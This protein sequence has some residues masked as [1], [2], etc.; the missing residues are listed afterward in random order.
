MTKYSRQREAIKNFLISRTDHPTAETV[1]ENIK[2]LYP[3]I[4]LGTVYRN[5]NYLCGTGEAVKI[6]CGD[7]REHYDGNTA[8]HYH[9]IC[10]ECSGVTDLYLDDLS[11]I[12]TLASSRFGGDIHGHNM[13]FYGICEKCKNS[14]KTIDI[15]EDNDILKQ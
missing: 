6:S 2:L 8:P 9:F 13:I 4:S 3:N 14:K 7:S 5:L 10:R 1:Y 12:N 11:F 15:S